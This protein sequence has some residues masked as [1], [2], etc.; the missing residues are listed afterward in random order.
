MDQHGV[1]KEISK[2]KEE[3]MTLVSSQTWCL[4]SLLYAPTK[5][6]ILAL[7]SEHIPYENQYLRT[8]M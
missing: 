1:Q 7:L 6:Q 8:F 2:Y 3:I 5:A 4:T